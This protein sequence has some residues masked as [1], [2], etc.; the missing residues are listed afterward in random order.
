MMDAVIKYTK[1]ECGDMEDKTFELLFDGYMQIYGNK[2]IMIKDLTSSRIR[3]MIYPS[4]S[5]RMM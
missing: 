1:E 5:Q 2:L 4:R 3:W